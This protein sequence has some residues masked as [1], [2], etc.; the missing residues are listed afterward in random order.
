MTA[1]KP[2]YLIQEASESH[3]PAQAQFS[4]ASEFHRLDLMASE[5]M[6]GPKFYICWTCRK[7]YQVGKGEVQRLA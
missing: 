1:R 7:V 6:R 3:C 2:I 4:P 5:S